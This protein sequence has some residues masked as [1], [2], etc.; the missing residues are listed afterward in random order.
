MFS[1]FLKISNNIEYI[2]VLLIIRVHMD[3]MDPQVLLDR[4]G[5]LEYHLKQDNG[6]M[7]VVEMEEKVKS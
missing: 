3:H 5:H 4:Q 6:Q 2:I 7:L 1:F